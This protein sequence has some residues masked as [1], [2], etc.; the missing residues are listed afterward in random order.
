[1]GCQPVSEK[2]DYLRV[3][4]SPSKIVEL[5]KQFRKNKRDEKLDETEYNSNSLTLD[6]RNYWCKDF[7]SQISSKYRLPNLDTISLRYLPVFEE[8]I[9]YFVEECMSETNSLLINDNSSQLVKLE[10]LEIE[11]YLDAINLAIPKVLKSLCIENFKLN[12]KQLAQI[13]RH[14]SHLKSVRFE[15]CDIDF[16]DSDTYSQ[17]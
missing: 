2:S 15:N 10:K 1:M 16:V 5:I 11:P 3:M 12:S 4:L 13:V 6:F 14:S 8:D 7:V 17:G 9:Q